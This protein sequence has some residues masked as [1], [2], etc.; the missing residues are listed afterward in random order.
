MKCSCP[1]GDPQ[2]GDAGAGWSRSWPIES[3]SGVFSEFA[4]VQASKHLDR[5]I[6]DLYAG[7]LAEERA[8]QR[9]AATGSRQPHRSRRVIDT[10]VTG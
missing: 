1:G 5:Q 3:A 4:A 10:R 2:A 9:T 7:G 8:P 6:L